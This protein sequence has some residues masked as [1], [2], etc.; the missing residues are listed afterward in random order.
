VFFSILPSQKISGVVKFTGSVKNGYFFE[1]NI[2]VNILDIN[3]KLLKGGH[4]TATT[5]WMTAAPVSFSGTFDLTSLPKGPAYIQIL[6][7]NASGLPENDKFILI[8]ITIE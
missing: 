7:D 4:G 6:N 8:P 2:I 1:G 5:E 3:Q